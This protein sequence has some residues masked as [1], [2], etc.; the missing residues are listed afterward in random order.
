MGQPI[1]H[2]VKIWPEYLDL[3]ESGALTSCVRRDDRGYTAGDILHVSEVD[4]VT[5][6][7]TGRDARWLITHV[8]RG[9]PRFGCDLHGFVVLSLRMA[10][11]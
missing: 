11:D 4:A 6:A 2:H 7:S 1:V 3:L 9:D 5:K 8:F 10:S